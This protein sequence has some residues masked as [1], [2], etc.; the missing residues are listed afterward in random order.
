MNP[1]LAQIDSVIHALKIRSNDRFSWFG[2]LSPSF[3]KLVPQD[4]FE[5]VARS[6][7]IS[8]MQN[9]LYSH[10]YCLGNA[11]CTSDSLQVIDSGLSSTAFIEELSKANQ[12][13]GCWENGWTI[14]EI[15]NENAIL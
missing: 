1:F 6:Q 5:N 12:G 9:E 10:F 4:L 13:K 11:A 3:A 8:L 14:V 15:N 2:K 7:M